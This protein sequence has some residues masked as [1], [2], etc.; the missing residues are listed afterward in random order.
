M[1]AGQNDPSEQSRGRAMIEAAAH[2]FR[3][4]EMVLHADLA[5]RFLRSG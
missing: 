2:D 5:E 1:L 4:L 3:S